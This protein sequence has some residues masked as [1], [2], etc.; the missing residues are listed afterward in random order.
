M[1]SQ[2]D[3][4]GRGVGQVYGLRAPLRMG[5]G[6]V[7]VVY[8]ATDGARMPAQ[9]VP[10]ATLDSGELIVLVND[11][12]PFR[13]AESQRFDRTPYAVFRLDLQG[14]IRFANPEA[15]RTLGLSR[16]TLCGT[17]LAAHFRSSDGPPVQSAILRC[18]Q[19]TEG[20]A[21]VAVTI[22]IPVPDEGDRQFELVMTPDPAP[23]GE[24]L[25]VIAVIQ[26]RT[27]ESARDEIRRI[28]LDPSIGGWRVKLDRILERIRAR[29][30]S[31]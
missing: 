10:I 22:A 30:R 19:D 13:Q 7:D 27:L 1:L 9:L 29:R 28:A 20:D 11:G 12:A 21:M 31:K 18:A 4:A 6:A 14:V 23:N 5:D 16:E 25:G 26:S 3:I 24:L 17:R 8:R 2:E 15:A